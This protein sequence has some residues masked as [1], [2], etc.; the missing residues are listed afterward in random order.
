MSKPIPKV[1]VVKSISKLC[2]VH[3][4]GSTQGGG[5]GGGVMYMYMYMA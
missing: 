5:G 4:L 2:S 3:A 1:K